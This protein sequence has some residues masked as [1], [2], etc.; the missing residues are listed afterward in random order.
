MD[1]L[2]GTKYED[3]SFSPGVPMGV[4]ALFTGIRL[5]TTSN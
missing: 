3:L 2:S 5:N 1:E 4:S